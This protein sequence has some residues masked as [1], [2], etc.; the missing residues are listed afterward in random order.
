[1]SK[2]AQVLKSHTDVNGVTLYDHLNTFLSEILK[3]NHQDLNTVELLSDFTKKNRFLFRALPSDK[4]VNSLRDSVP[5][6]KEWANRVGAL[7]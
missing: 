1:M 7:L 4:E 5:E 3:T 6:F 2:L